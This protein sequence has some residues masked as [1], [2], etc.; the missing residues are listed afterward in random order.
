MMAFDTAMVLGAVSCAAASLSAFALLAGKA[1][2]SGF[3]IVSDSPVITRDHGECTP[4]EHRCRLFGWLS[5][6]VSIDWDV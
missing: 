1:R 3:S 6:G 2:G 5:R 4:E